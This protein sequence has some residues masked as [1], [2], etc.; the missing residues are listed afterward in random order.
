MAMKIAPNQ[1]TLVTEIGEVRVRDPGTG[2]SMRRS[3]QIQ[4][5]ATRVMARSGTKVALKELG[6]KMVARIRFLANMAMVVSRQ[7]VL[8]RLTIPVSRSL[9]PNS[10]TVALL[11]TRPPKMALR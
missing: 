9:V 11:F 1:I 3:C 7:R 4:K 2:S 8:T 10:A 5:P 6:E